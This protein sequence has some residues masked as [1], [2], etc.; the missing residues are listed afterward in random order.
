MA[1]FKTNSLFRPGADYHLNACVG[2]NGG[3]YDFYD[4]SLG[5]LRAARAIA[6]AAGQPPL[7]VDIAVYPL[8]FNFRHGIELALKYFA[9]TLPPLFDHHGSP[10]LTHRLK[11]NW[12]FVE[13]FVRRDEGFSPNETIPPFSQLVDDLVHFDPKGEVFRFPEDRAGELYLQDASLI[14]VGVLAEAIAQAEDIVSFWQ[15]HADQVAE[16]RRQMSREV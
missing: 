2:R 12:T 9:I 1:R 8:V 5:Y 13:P 3:P 7:A 14:N 15:F 11:D 6:A 16:Y 10:A 4:Y